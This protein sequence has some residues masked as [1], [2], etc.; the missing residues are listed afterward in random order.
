MNN[1]SDI[2]HVQRRFAL[3]AR[4]DADLEGS[5]PLVGYVLQ[6]SVRKALE[7]MLGGIAHGGRFAFT[8]TGPY[9]GGKS[10]AA[11][12]VANLVGGSKR[13]KKLAREIAG[14]EL[15]T[16]FDEAFGPAAAGWKVLALTGRRSSLVDAI[17]EGLAAL[18]YEQPHATDDDYR[19][20]IDALADATSVSKGLM[21]IVD[22]MGKFLDHAIDE[23]GD[24]HFLQDLGERTARS[25]GK[26]IFV[27]ILHQSFEQYSGRIGRSAR[28][29]WAKVQ[30]RFQNIPFIAQPDEV[31]ALLAQAII[32]EERPGAAAKL[33]LATAQAVGKR[34]PID[35]AS[36]AS[37]LERIWP[38]HPVT[39]M[40]LGPVSRQR[41]AQNERS[42]FGFLSSAEPFGFQSFLAT[43]NLG[44]TFS[45]DMLWDYLVANFGSALELGPDGE[46]LTIAMEAVQRAAVKGSIHAMV[47]KAAVIIELFRNGSGLAV[48]EDILTLCVP[49]AQRGVVPQILADLVDQAVLI[50][51]PRLGGYAIFAGSDFDLDDAITRLSDGLNGSTL[52][53]LPTQ[54]GVGPVVAKR[55]YFLTGALRAYD[56]V[57]MFSENVGRDPGGWAAEIVKQLAKGKRTATGMLALILPDPQSF[58]ASLDAAAK[59]LGKSL[60]AQG[61]VSAVAVVQNTFMLRE[62]VVELYAVERVEAAHPQLQGDKIARRQ[63]L[64]RRTHLKDSVR[65]EILAA[66]GAAAW[67]TM[68]KRERRLDGE[69]LTV[70]ATALS[71]ATFDKAPVVRSEL[72]YRDKA[73]GSAIAARRALMH[74]MVQRGG[75]PN[76]GFSGYPAERGLYMTVLGP[77]GL[78]RQDGSG[79]WRFT[80][81]DSSD[82]GASLVPA[83]QAAAE[84]PGFDL[85]K[86]YRLWGNRPFGLKQ[87]IMPVLALALLLAHRTSMAIYLDGRYEVSIDD[88]FVDRMLQSPSSVEFRRV[89]RSE[90][91]QVFID[92]LADRLSS[93]EAQVESTAL[94]VASALYKRFHDLPAWSQRT[95]S[96]NEATRRIRDVVLKANDPEALLFADLPTAMKDEFDPALAVSTALFESEKAY[97]AMLDGLRKRL[98]ELLGVDVKTFEGLGARAMSAAG[99]TRDLRAEAFIMRAGAF[100]GE[101]GDI[102]GLASLLVHKPARNWSDSEQERAEFEMAKL[103]RRFREAEAFAEV[104]GRAATATA[105]SVVIG[106]D[107]KERPLFRALDVTERELAEADRIADDLVARLRLEGVPPTVEIAALARMLERISGDD[108]VQEL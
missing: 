14:P 72:L 4:L 8:W 43:A 35:E 22:E 100:E 71:D 89:S 99:V 91:D 39:A 31:A 105:I 102:E 68:G 5:P 90:R 21:V 44:S 51:Q 45:P 53:D 50:A 92:R 3:S 66:F 29:E 78:H 49:A 67:W 81:P 88:V 62:R 63:L 77:F 20:V 30:G 13:Q 73:S 56:V 15:S 9:G 27:G 104:R 12:L 2:V 60:E 58:E 41:F 26:L 23:G 97:P 6:A 24:V 84:M 48:A 80:D 76:L 65:K 16:A 32:S 95:K 37:V 96:L 28:D 107:P 83:W 1:L 38:L 57:L 34:R 86:L 54:L 36:L 25:G 87:G 59:A 55:H 7:A 82:A 79:D 18:G 61:I 11:L 74:A 108:E 33:A 98:A 19:P 106:L 103:A 85:G 64:A 69:P 93:K 70:V 42:V 10:S 75:Q 46:R 52:F 101:E 94:A 17:G 40:L 47:T